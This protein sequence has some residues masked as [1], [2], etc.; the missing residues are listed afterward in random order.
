MP[1]T[2]RSKTSPQS[3]PGSYAPKPA[4][5]PAIDPLTSTAECVSCHGRGF[6]DV[7]VAGVGGEPGVDQESCDSCDADRMELRGLAED[8]TDR[9][10]N[11]YRLDVLSLIDALDE[12]RGDSGLAARNEMRTALVT[13][14]DDQGNVHRGALHAAL[15]GLPAVPQP[16]EQPEFYDS[17]FGF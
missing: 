17:G 1:V 7:M 15:D 9:Q 6:H 4:T 10:G 5:P 3:T 16:V 13:A 14:S 8:M 11:V 12:Q 2:P